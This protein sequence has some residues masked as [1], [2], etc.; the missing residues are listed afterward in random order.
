ML[1]PAE[2]RDRCDISR[3][4]GLLLSGVVAHLSTAKHAAAQTGS[5][6]EWPAAASPK[7]IVAAVIARAAEQFRHDCGSCHGEDGRGGPGREF[8]RKTPDFTDATWQARRSDRQLI[9]SILNGKGS[10]MP[11]GG[12]RLSR[13]QARDLVAYI[14][15]FGRFTKTGPKPTSENQAAIAVAPVDQMDARE[16]RQTENGAAQSSFEQSFTQLEEQMRELQDEYRQ[17]SDPSKRP[18]IAIAR[19]MTNEITQSTEPAE[20]GTFLLH[21]CV[22]CHAEVDVR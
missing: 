13:E 7:D 8:L 10:D 22:N 15:T 2:I 17:L 18:T 5:R 16:S 6:L 9:A 1:A 21:S 12:D 20:A 14:R 4:F 11:A 19:Q 3:I